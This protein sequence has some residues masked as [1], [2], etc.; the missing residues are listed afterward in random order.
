M[1]KSISNCLRQFRRE[2]PSHHKLLLR[3]ID[4][5]LSAFDSLKLDSRRLSSRFLTD[6]LYLANLHITPICFLALASN[7]N[8]G[9]SE[10]VRDDF[11]A[12][13]FQLACQLTRIA[14]TSVCIVQLVRDGFDTQAR[15]LLRSLNESVYQLLILFSDA[16][17]Y[18]IYQGA[19]SVEDTKRIWYELFGGKKRLLKKLSALE[20][21]LGV[22]QRATDYLDSWRAGAMDFY[23]ETIH[24]GV[25][26][27]TWGSLSRDFEEDQVHLALLGMASPS[28]R[29]TLD[30]LTFQL[31]YFSR[32][33]QA[34]LLQVHH[35]VPDMDS[36]YVY[37]YFAMD[38]VLDELSQETRK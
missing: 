12:N 22:P 27:A 10:I 30:H 18:Q 28:S 2:N 34:L 24:H 17:D 32:M 6:A 20:R 38:H 19:T 9:E 36:E 37:K 4:S 31:Q 7:K 23:G 5:H 21:V 13:D 1:R 8:K 3:D 29:S 14:N 33:I 16:A 15:I 25:Y 35:W 11:P 26:S